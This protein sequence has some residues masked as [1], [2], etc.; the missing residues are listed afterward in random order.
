MQPLAVIDAPWEPQ[1]ASSSAA[2][3]ARMQL[4]SEIGGSARPHIGSRVTALVD[5]VAT[6]DPEGPQSFQLA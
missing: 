1:L 6:T 2:N 4:I 5:Y 3:R